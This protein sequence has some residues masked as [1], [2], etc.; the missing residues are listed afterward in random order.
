MLAQW[1][2]ITIAILS[3]VQT[4]NSSILAWS[5]WR[6]PGC[7]WAELYNSNR[8]STMFATPSV[9]WAWW[10]LAIRICFRFGTSLSLGACFANVLSLGLRV[11]FLSCSLRIGSRANTPSRWILSKL[12]YVMIQLSLS[13][14]RCI[15]FR[16][17]IRDSSS[18]PN[19]EVIPFTVLLFLVDSCWVG[20]GFFAS[21]ALMALI[22]LLNCI[23][24]SSVGSG[25]V[26]GSTS[27]YL[28]KSISNR[29]RR[30]MRR[31]LT[32]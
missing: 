5:S 28:A 24:Y 3:R 18:H 16:P 20:L 1:S 15:R 23:W 4:W 14:P 2:Q 8:L 26:S 17:Y 7:P 25:T 29:G 22:I 27:L 9:Q 11:P 21:H 12:R 6:P 32:R 13:H 31:W 30:F 10:C 19:T